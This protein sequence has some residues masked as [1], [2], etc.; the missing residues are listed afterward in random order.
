[1]LQEEATYLRQVRVILAHL[2]TN[3]LQEAARPQLIVV[4]AVHCLMCHRQNGAT[5]NTVVL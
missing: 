5:S 4:E 3:L 2:V 1:V